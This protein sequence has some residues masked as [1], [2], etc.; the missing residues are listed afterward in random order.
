MTISDWRK[1]YIKQHSQITDCTS[2]NNVY[3]TSISPSMMQFFKYLALL[4]LTPSL[5]GCPS[6]S[7]VSPSYLKYACWR[8]VINRPF[9]VGCKH[10]NF[11]ISRMVCDVDDNEDYKQFVCKGA[12]TCKALF[13]KVGHFFFRIIRMGELW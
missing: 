4:L 11:L 1:W 7:D 9:A 2:G 8:Q 3:I 13:E 12:R 5:H 6:Q 10:V